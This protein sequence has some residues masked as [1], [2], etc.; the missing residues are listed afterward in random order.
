M[1][2][3]SD[4]LYIWSSSKEHLGPLPSNVDSCCCFL[5]QEYEADSLDHSE[6]EPK[7]E[8]EDNPGLVKGFSRRRRGAVS[9]APMTEEDATSYVKKVLLF[10]LLAF[11]DE[12]RHI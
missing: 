6:P 10:D 12:K 2:I 8:I 4:F 1:L 9:A 5:S 3:I 7:H 11:V